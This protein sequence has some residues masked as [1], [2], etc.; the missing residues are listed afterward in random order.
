MRDGA[1]MMRRG[2]TRFAEETVQ[3]KRS[4]LFL[5]WSK[6][7]ISPKSRVVY[8]LNLIIGVLG[9]FTLTYDTYQVFIGSAKFL[10]TLFLQ[11]IFVFDMI[12]KSQTMYH[13]DMQLVRNPWH[14]IRR[15][16]LS[17]FIV[18]LLANAPLFLIN[19]SLL[20]WIRLF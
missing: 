12:I 13:R 2:S 4:A 9:M 20:S 15:Y 7:L 3:E 16:L 6:N 1:E 17:S 18:D 14:V 8:W 5:W 11:P 10:L 19:E